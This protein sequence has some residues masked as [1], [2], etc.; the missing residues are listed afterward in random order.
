MSLGLVLGGAAEGF[1]EG[2]K[3]RNKIDEAKELKK[4]RKRDEDY[5]VQVQHAPIPGEEI[6]TNY[7]PAAASKS[8]LPP[9][10]PHQRFGL[11]GKLLS[12]IDPNTAAAKAGL[13]TPGTAPL[14]AGLQAPADAAA[15]PA[16][17]PSPAAG[18]APPAPA[19]GL[20]TGDAEVAPV[21]VTAGPRKRKATA[22]DTA[23]YMV[24]AAR[25]KGDAKALTEAMGSF[26]KATQDE[27]GQELA[28]QGNSWTGLANVAHRYAGMDMD[29]EEGDNGKAKVTIGGHDQG[30][31]SLD[32]ARDK[33][34]E[35]ATKTPGFA[36]TAARQR[37]AD[38]RLALAGRTDA[39]YKEA[40]AAASTQNA[41]TQA[42]L[43]DSTVAQ[44]E[45]ETQ[46]LRQKGEAQ[47]TFQQML[48]QGDAVLNAYDLRRA[49]R[50]AY[51]PVSKVVQ[52][53]N[54]NDQIV[55][56]NPG[57][58]IADQAMHEQ[59]AR[60][61]ASPYTQE[62]VGIIF[63]SA[64]PSTGQKRWFV[65]GVPGQAFAKFQDAEYAAR[66]THPNVKPPAKGATPPAKGK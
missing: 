28:V 1:G 41:A 3:L 2:V 27:M 35:Y 13:A 12:K 65:K 48:T 22:M 6:D 44:N 57:D 63:P 38:E 14:G 20:P 54:G 37:T 11:V 19:A 60:V 59:E 5:R 9:A 32:E 17:G 52:D 24:H 10:T 56:I 62:G 61:R 26:D 23:L 53:A 47:R 34:T 29:F 7:D 18:A 33:M 55:T 21:E 31:M 42:K 16:A 8:A 4:A 30:E 66:K 25:Q 46:N 36:A 43:A 15:A 51:D 40:V 39:T 49:A 64:D 45:V 58:A 50:L